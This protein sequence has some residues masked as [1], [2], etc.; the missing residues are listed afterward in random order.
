MACRRI[1][2]ESHSADARAT[3]A[4]RYR[5]AGTRPWYQTMEAGVLDS[6][7][8]A[9]AP[10]H[11]LPLYFLIL[12]LYLFVFCLGLRRRK[13]FDGQVVLMFLAIH[14]PIKAALEFLRFEYGLLHQIV[15]PVGIAA[16]AILLARRFWNRGPKSLV[17]APASI[18]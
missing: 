18:G 12:E 6:V 9:S 1:A 14:G 10:V 16:L 4:I 15:L 7:A 5:K 11:P 17:A 3:T 13:R 8:S 2:S